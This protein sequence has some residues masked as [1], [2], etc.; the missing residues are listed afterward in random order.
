M[1]K[2]SILLVFCIISLSLYA[3][4]DVLRVAPGAE[5]QL[6]ALLN[7]PAMVTPANVTPL[8]R[9]WFKVE[10]DAHAFTDQVNV[11]QVTAA[12]L[13][14]ESYNR[15]FDGKRTKITTKIVN[16]TKEELVIDFVTIAI[17]PVINIRLNTPYRAIVKTLTQTDTALSVDVRQ[18]PQ[19]SETNGKIKQLYAPRYVEEATINGKK[20]T[21]IRMYSIM[22]VDASILPGA[23]GTLER[24]AVPTNE[25]GMELLI[26]AAKT[27]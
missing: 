8:G 18:L 10:T 23:K 27:K 11:R 6:S 1:R 13:D 26:A 21:Y 7:K 12:L 24:N 14:I 9:N 2:Y 17:V 3:Q 16:S 5:A 19:D 4:A 22:D 25:E 15:I 20:Y